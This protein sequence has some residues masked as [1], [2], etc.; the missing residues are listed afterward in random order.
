MAQ[1]IVQTAFTANNRMSG[2]LVNLQNGFRNLAASA[3]TA[4]AAMNSTTSLLGQDV[5]NRMSFMTSMA[6]TMAIIGTITASGKALMDYDTA[7]SKFRIIVSELNDVD[8]TKFRSKAKDIAIATRSSTIDVVNMFTAIAGFDDRLAATPEILESVTTAAIKMGRGGFMEA[9]LA[10][11]SLV[12]TLAMFKMSGNESMRVA[13][14]IAAGQNRGAFS[15]QQTSDALVNFGATAKGANMEVENAVGVLQALAAKGLDAAQAGTAL[16]AIIL[17]VQQSGKGYRTGKF[18]FIEGLESIK[19]ISDKMTE[20]G[21]NTLFADIFGTMR[22]DEGRF[23][24]ENITRIKEFT[25]AATGTTESQKAFDI[26]NKGV[27]STLN[28]LRDRWITLVT[29]NQ[30]AKDITDKFTNSIRWV[31]DNLETFGYWAYKAAK[32]FLFYK[33]VTAG[34][35]VVLGLYNAALGINNFL[36]GFNAVLNRQSTVALVG[37]KAAMMGATFATRLFTMST[38]GLVAAV[39]GGIAVLG[40]FVWWMTDLTGKSDTMNVSLDKSEQR[41]LELKKP[42]DAATLS[43]SAYNAEVTKTNDLNFEIQQKLKRRELIETG[44]LRPSLKD[45]IPEFFFGKEQYEKMLKRQM[46]FNPIDKRPFGLDTVNLP[47]DT[48]AIPMSFNMPSS[49]DKIEISLITDNQTQARV[50]RND[51]GIPVII[52]QTGGSPFKTANA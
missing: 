50:V 36:I 10:A 2:T 41:F 3:N 25:K 13:N 28:Q 42:I 46:N 18:D 43:L 37:N 47:T 32:V 52:N 4:N 17:R 44:A 23:L 6:K 14:A 33:V 38:W 48:T 20:R 35:A 8:F 16:N 7:L 26:A 22:V 49:K 31:T 21:R 51:G 15:I 40:L 12:T 27:V 30:K 5:M 29:E 34:T 24:L 9:D 19:G 39:T 45:R 1:F 11:K